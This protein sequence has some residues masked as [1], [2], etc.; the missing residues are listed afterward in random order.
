METIGSL[1]PIS[2]PTPASDRDGRKQNQPSEGKSEKVR[3]SSM[4]MELVLSSA[5]VFEG[6]HLELYG[7]IDRM[8]ITIVRNLE[9]H[10]QM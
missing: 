4:S 3:V 10:S 2:L 9:L 5:E 6:S 8:M 1:L 7:V